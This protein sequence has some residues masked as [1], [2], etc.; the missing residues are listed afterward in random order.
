MARP[1]ALVTGA[2]SGIG[3][4]FARELASRGH[5]LI[6]VARG[7]DALKTLAA[8]LSDQREVE[9]EVLPADLRDP[10]GLA[11][12]ESRVGATERPVDV[13]VNN[14]GFGS[15][16]S[17]VD[18]PVEGEVGQVELNVAAL[19]RLTHAAL[20]QMVPRGA[21]GILNVASVGGFQP[22]PGNATY[23]ATKAFV[24]SFTEAVHDEV[25]RDGVRVTCLC[26][27]FTRTAFQDR[28]GLEAAAVPGFLW[29]DPASV[30]RAGLKALQRNKAVC[31]PGLVNKGA[32]GLVRLLPR[33]AV[34]RIAGVAVKR[35][36]R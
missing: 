17:F 28:A 31:I 2:S 14:A 32:P 19:L 15:G 23:S 29:S 1:L 10:A 8:E 6:L 36:E 22:A 7:A 11:A 16:G 13:L 25:V 5:D 24:L 34:R 4:A 20:R 33:A 18:L 30:A 3:E 26:P 12:V 27:G 35:M 21:G 9:A